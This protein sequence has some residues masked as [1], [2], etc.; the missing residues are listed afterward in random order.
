M[1][2]KP[3]RAPSHAPKP[4]TPK[5]GALTGS[6]RAS[7]R[8]T[9]GDGSLGDGSED[10]DTENID[11]SLLE[12]MQA[13]PDEGTVL[14]RV[15][16][17]IE[18]LENKYAGRSLVFA[19]KP[20]DDS[21]SEEIGRTV[22]VYERDPVVVQDNVRRHISEVPFP[23]WDGKDTVIEKAESPLASPVQYYDYEP[24]LK[25]VDDESE[26]ED[27]DN[28]DA[29]ARLVR[30]YAN[31][32]MKQAKT[33]LPQVTAALALR[34][35]EN[36]M[37]ANCSMACGGAI[38]LGPYLGELAG[39]NSLDLSTNM[40][41]DE[42][43]TSLAKALRA[44]PG[45]TYLHLDNNK[46]GTHGARALAEQFK[47]RKSNLT[48]FSVRHNQLRYAVMNIHHNCLLFPTSVPSDKFWTLQ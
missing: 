1:S 8:R 21:Y 35:C 9:G 42:G 43:A 2:A 23:S 34:K 4:V 31:S 3:R 46:L 15:E 32:C 44:C 45:L 20:V 19:G 36:L 11:T 41:F 37:L 24:D 27:E 17:W 14:R 7:G 13:G 38:S 10:F 22:S 5:R 30:A 12:K 25:H 39:L 16:D 26:D 6:F 18:G 40:I 47:T 48:Y 29:G 28:R 33:A